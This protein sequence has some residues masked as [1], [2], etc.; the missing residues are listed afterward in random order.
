MKKRFIVFIVFA[1][2]IFG[3]ILFFKISVAVKPPIISD[4]S[5]LYKERIQIDEYTYRIDNSWLK[6][7]DFGLWELYLKGDDFELGAINGKLT[8]ELSNY[9]EEAFVEQIK[10]LVPSDFMLRFLKYFI[11]WFNRDIDSYIPLEY[12]REIYGVSLSAS[13]DFEFIAPNYQ[14]ILNYHAAHDIGH[15]IDNL[16]MVACTAFGVK[17]NNSEDSTLLVGRNMDFYSGDKFAENKIVAFCEPEKGYPFAYVTWAGFVGVISGMNNQGLTIT[18]NS[19][20][21][22]IPSSAKTP[23]SLLARNILQY[24]STLDEAFTIAR[25]NET[26]VAESFFISSA[27]DSDFAIIEKSTDTTVLYNPHENE[28]ILTNHY[29]DNAFKKRAL[30]IQNKKET[31]TVYR[32]KRAEELLNET[33]QHNVESFVRILRNQKGLKN[34]DLG[35][36]NETC[37]NQLIAHHSVVFKPEQLQMWIS[38]GPYQLG[39]Y[40]AYDLNTIFADSTD[41]TKNIYSENLTIEKDTFLASQHYAD[42]IEYKEMTLAFHNAIENDNYAYVTQENIVYYEKLNPNY[43]NTYATIGECYAFLGEKEKAKQYYTKALTK[44]IS[45]KRERDA[46]QEKISQLSEES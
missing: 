27:K 28:L 7:N 31:E 15:A 46:I 8:K 4:T 41:L 34:E 32:W 2:I 12:Q 36:G 1:A 23:V 16:N 3:L 21:S 42:F 38:V 13:K 18:L 24:A 22:D 14:R 33:P 30:T 26:F 39:E 40:I 37:I 6:K 20:K 17:N 9:Q 35:Y 25:N 43:Y 29:Q 44:N 11:A 45:K 10:E 5:A 19:A